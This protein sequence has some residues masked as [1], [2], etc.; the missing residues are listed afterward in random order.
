MVFRFNIRTFKPDVR[1]R[2]GIDLLRRAQFLVLRSFGPEYE[3]REPG[4]YSVEVSIPQLDLPSLAYTIVAFIG[5]ATATEADVAIRRDP[6]KFFLASNTAIVPG[7]VD[8]PRVLTSTPLEIKDCNVLVSPRPVRLGSVAV[9][10]R[11]NRLVERD[12]IEANTFIVDDG[13]ALRVRLG[14]P[15]RTPLGATPAW[16]GLY[17]DKELIARSQTLEIN[18][19]AMGLLEIE[20]EIPSGLISS[21][22]FVLSLWLQPAK[23][24]K[25]KKRLSESIDVCIRGRRMAIATGPTAFLIEGSTGAMMEPEFEWAVCLKSDT[26]LEKVESANVG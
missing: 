1:V 2:P 21:R 6:V 16:F 14:I 11:E 8:G 10:G 4:I 3:L 26:R 24:Q 7:D 5:A 25:G 13:E 18:F 9:L 19:S 20:C 22:Q 17:S 23:A 15:I 12:P